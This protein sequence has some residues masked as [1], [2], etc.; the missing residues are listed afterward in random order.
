[1]KPK[2]LL[3]AAVLIALALP[4]AAHGKEVTG[5]ALCGPSACAEADRS[6]GHQGLSLGGSI[7]PAPVGEYYRV[8]FEVDGEPTF[9]FYYVPAPGL[10][11]SQ[12]DTGWTQWLRPAPAFAGTLRR[13]ARRVEP[14]PAPKVT[15]V[16]LDGRRL[17][18]DP[19]SYLE[20]FE[21]GGRPAYPGDWP[22]LRLAF[23]A[24]R[25]SPWTD[26]RLAYFP[27]DDVLQL[28]PGRFVH[29]PADVAADLETSRVRASVPAQE[30][31][32]RRTAAVG[33]AT[34]LGVVAVGAA[35]AGS[36]RRR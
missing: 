4:G 30:Q 18:G 23:T 26:T 22:I 32:D 28:A 16:R 7:A 20:L 15:S 19:G 12:T 17:G 13:L 35:V 29:I 31:P 27:R 2:P 10:I 11:T 36:R 9:G 21:L 3:A 8:E 14:F 5:V 1:V 34:A 33:L 24:K 6:F 25:R